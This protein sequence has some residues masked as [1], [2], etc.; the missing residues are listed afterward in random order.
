MLKHTVWNID[1]FI[2]IF[3]F[4][5]QNLTTKHCNLNNVNTINMNKGHNTHLPHIRSSTRR[6]RWTII[7]IN[8][9]LRETWR[10]GKE[11]R[12]TLYCLLVN[13]DMAYSE[14][15]LN[16]QI[17]WVDI[18]LSKIHNI[19]SIFIFVHFYF[20]NVY[21]MHIQ[22]GLCWYL[23]NIR[24]RMFVTL[25]S[26]AIPTTHTTTH[27]GSGLTTFLIGMCCPGI[28]QFNNNGIESCVN[29]YESQ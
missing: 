10:N 17:F 6:H 4:F 14:Q 3:V 7:M 26:T 9:G 1:D 18:E 15:S 23:A 25:L 27:D 20:T 5:C 29:I 11:R 21:S 24:H 19:Y 22:D 28:Y 8:P 2:C 12:N 16:K 13:A